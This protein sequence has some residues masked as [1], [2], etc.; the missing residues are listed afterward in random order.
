MIGRGATEKGGIP[1]LPFWES[2]E[3][4]LEGV[5]AACR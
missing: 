5:R 2:M 3:G 1:R 4:C